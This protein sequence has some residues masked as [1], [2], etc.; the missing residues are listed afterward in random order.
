MHLCAGKFVVLWVNAKDLRGNWEPRRKSVAELNALAREL[1]LPE[2][3]EALGIAFGR[4]IH[5][6]VINL[7]EK[8]LL[9]AHVQWVGGRKRIRV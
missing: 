2:A 4:H 9:L 3:G 7:C 1:F 5:L 6:K 8:V